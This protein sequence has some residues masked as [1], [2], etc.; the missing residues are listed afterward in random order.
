MV[1]TVDHSLS[2]QVPNA[3]YNTRAMLYLLLLYSVFL[4][5]LRIDLRLGRYLQARRLKE[6]LYALWNLLGHILA[7]P[8]R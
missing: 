3:S 8:L 2:W 5:L 1:A 4:V 6:E 7:R